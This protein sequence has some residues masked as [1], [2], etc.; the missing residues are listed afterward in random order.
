MKLFLKKAR[1]IFFKINI[2]FEEYE[3][4]LQYNLKDALV[5]L[6]INKDWKS[7]NQITID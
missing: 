6:S 5:K 2:T 3:K 7:Q 1:I 4:V